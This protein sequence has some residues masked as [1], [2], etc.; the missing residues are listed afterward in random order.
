VRV[1]VVFVTCL[2]CLLVLAACGG[3]DDSEAERD[4]TANSSG[5]PA[6]DTAVRNL[7]YGPSTE[8]APHYQ[9]DV[10][11]I[12]EGPAAIRSVS[13][14]GLTYTI[15][16][17][18]DGASQLELGSIMLASSRATGR[19]VA[20]QDDGDN[21]VVTLAPVGIADLVRDGEISVDMDIDAS[22][23]TYLE[24][25]DLPGKVSEPAATTEEASEETTNAA[26]VVRLPVIHLVAA[27]RLPDASTES[28][29]IP[30]GDD[31][32]VQPLTGGGRLGLKVTHSGEELK[33]GASIALDA[34]NMHVRAGETVSGGS[35]SN[36]NFTIEGIKAVDISLEA[37]IASGESNGRIRVEVPVEI[38]IP[39]PPGPETAFL[40]LDVK[41]EFSALVETALSGANSTITANGTYGLAGPIGLKDGSA[42]VPKFT[43]KKSLLDNIGG[44]PVGVSGVVVGVK[45]KLQA[46]VGTASVSAGPYGSIITSVGLTNGSAL[47]AALAQCKNETLIVSVNG[48]AGVSMSDTV[49]DALSKLL[50]KGTDLEPDVTLV[51]EEIVNRDVTA[52]DVPL[53]RG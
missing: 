14:D 53:C 3:D 23:F 33:V 21:R 19:V 34:P 28:K 5:A 49:K 15:D 46:G 24:V 38:D 29:E 52:P 39:I 1:R 37:G 43:V 4:G 36:Y 18:A 42:V 30:L 35:T 17:N 2:T 32:S 9:P 16:R 6:G 13:S 7:G 12:S 45:T 11:A 47:G 22:D 10:V 31:W 26:G 41:V 27:P 51:D 20:L 50:P 8:A 44:I 40:P 48:G 25:P